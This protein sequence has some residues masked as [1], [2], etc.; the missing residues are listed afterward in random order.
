MPQ[1]FGQVA[2]DLINDLIL[3]YRYIYVYHIWILTSGPK[4][5]LRSLSMVS[6]NTLLNMIHDKESSM[7]M[8]HLPVLATR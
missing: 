6:R 4:L 3:V 7:G 5:N 2:L 8:I 1:T